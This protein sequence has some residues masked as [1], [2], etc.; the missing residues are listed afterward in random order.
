ME[1]WREARPPNKARSDAI[2]FP[3][4][5]LGASMNGQSIRCDLRNAAFL[6]YPP[7]PPDP[8]RRYK[9][10]AAPVSRP[11]AQCR[12]NRASNA[13][14]T[15]RKESCKPRPVRPRLV[16]RME[17]AMSTAR[18]VDGIWIGSWRGNSENLTRVEAALSLVKQHSP[19]DYARITRELERIWVTLSVYERGQYHHALRAC[20]LDERYVA[21]SAT[22]VEQ[23]ASTIVHEATHA[24]LERYGIEY[25]EELRTRIEAICFRRELAFAVRLPNSAEPQEI[26]RRLEWYQSNP[27][28][29]SD[30]QFREHQTAGGA[31]ALRYLG[32]PDWLIR[33]VLAS[34]SIIGRVR[35]LSPIVAWAISVPLVIGFGLSYAFAAFLDPKADSKSKPPGGEKS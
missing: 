10:C 5:G 14:C 23:I 4:A 28:Q 24:R 3:L 2:T 33:A 34:R 20:I 31:E 27:D 32:A 29:F 9:I 6:S 21:D 19:L 35:R 25:K 18:H 17:L 1:L 22:T 16:D 11:K 13:E 26:A 15:M 7:A 12:I 30:A 8:I